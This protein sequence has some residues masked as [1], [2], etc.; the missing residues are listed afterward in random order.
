MKLCQIGTHHN[1]GAANDLHAE[2]YGTIGKLLAER[3]ELV[4]ALQALVTAEEDYGDQSNVAVNEAWEPAR[5][6]LA[7]IEKGK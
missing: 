5:A 2:C 7:R 1:H 6:L 4:E 3:A